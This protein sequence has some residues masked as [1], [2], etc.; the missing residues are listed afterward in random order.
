MNTKNQANKVKDNY[1]KRREG[2][3]E[4]SSKKLNKKWNCLVRNAIATLT[5]K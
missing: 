1:R 4:T 2:E 5:Y 3:R